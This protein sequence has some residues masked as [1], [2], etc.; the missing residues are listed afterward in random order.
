MG[1]STVELASR[2]LRLERMDNKRFESAYSSLEHLFR[3]LEQ[4]HQPDH[5]EIGWP[6]D[7]RRTGSMRQ[8]WFGF[9]VYE[10]VHL[11]ERATRELGA[12][13][14]LRGYLV[15]PERPKVP[16]SDL[17]DYM[18][19]KTKLEKSVIRPWNERREHRRAP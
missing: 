15:H 14:V 12:E 5:P 8:T 10:F 7:I 2:L 3:T 4:T 16:W 9:Y 19:L 17:A 13:V 18:D 6:V 11:F 1:C